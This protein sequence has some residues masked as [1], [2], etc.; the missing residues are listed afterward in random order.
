MFTYYLSRVV[1]NVAGYMYP[2]YLSY[3]AVKARDED[4][5]D[6]WLTHWIVMS[7]F[8]IAE[9]PGDMLLFWLPLYYELKLLIVLWLVLPYTQGS[10]ILYHQL[11]Q[12]T[13]AK[14]EPEID[15][16]IWNAQ[17]AARQTVKKW[18]QSFF[19]RIREVAMQ[20][21]LTGQLNF[22]TTP[23]TSA[24]K[25]QKRSSRRVV[26]VSS[27]SS[28]DDRLAAPAPQ[29]TAPSSVVTPRAPPVLQPRRSPRKRVVA[30]QPVDILSST[31]A[32]EPSDFDMDGTTDILS[33]E[34]ITYEDYGLDDDL[35]LPR[36]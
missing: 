7:F 35:P 13:L 4:A 36:G 32:G 21:I 28:E 1:G 14:H 20:S 6:R 22:T 26:E 10:T 23:A 24:K 18:G 11:L 9:I 15:A 30:R 27:E 5:L 3:K 16:A 33:E 12:P 19:E 17:Q 8:T 31:S 29:P 25:R 2:A 34:D